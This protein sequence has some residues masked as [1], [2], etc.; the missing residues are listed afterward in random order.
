[1]SEGI[2]EMLGKHVI[3]ITKEGHVLPAVDVL[4]LDEVRP[5]KRGQT[6]FGSLDAAAAKAGLSL[7]AGETP[8]L[9]IRDGAGERP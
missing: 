8:K 3:R 5:R 2:Q 9:P 1:M 6:G 4:G 7:N